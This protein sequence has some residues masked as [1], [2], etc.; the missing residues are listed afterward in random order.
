MSR[1]R[2]GLTVAA[3]VALTVMSAQGQDNFRIVS[4]V[5]RSDPTRIRLNGSVTNEGRLDVIDVSVTAEALDA[6]G[7]VLARGISFVSSSIPQGG[8][9][10]FV[11]SVPP[12]PGAMTFRV[13]VTS[14][15]FGLGLQAP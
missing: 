12:V 11:A 2:A 9:A 6:S 7:K 10:S 15:R 4:R 14:F 1:L 8:S 5:D 13:R 3:L